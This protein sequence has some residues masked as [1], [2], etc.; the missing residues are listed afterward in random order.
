[1]LAV[2]A[3]FL[4]TETELVLKSR[5]VTP[6]RLVE[7]G[8]TFDYPDWATAAVDLCSRWRAGRHGPT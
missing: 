5:R 4:Q 7:A 6:R 8:F 2:G 3:V 1:M